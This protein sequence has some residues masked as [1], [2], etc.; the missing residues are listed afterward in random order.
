MVKRTAIDQ[1]L[2]EV[3]RKLK[4]SCRQVSVLDRRMDILQRRYKKANE[5]KARA[6]FS[7]LRLQLSTLEGVRQAFYLYA[8][9]RV[10]EKSH[11]KE[12]VRHHLMRTTEE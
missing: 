7:S 1:K 12:E 9:D 2:R 10:A 4:A 6:V 3:E 11:L 5:N 8:C